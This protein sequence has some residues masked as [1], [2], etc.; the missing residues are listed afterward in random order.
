MA[1]YLIAEHLINDRAQFEEYRSNVAPMIERF[2]GRYITRGGSH[3]VL[4]GAWKPTRVVIIEFPD[5]AMLKSWDHSPDYQP[6]IELRRR[7]ATD[8]LIAL[9]GA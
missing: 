9:E 3:E 5:M 8:V 2:G 7:A 1:A 6:L 4:D